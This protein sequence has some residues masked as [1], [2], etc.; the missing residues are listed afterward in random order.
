MIKQL[1][2]EIDACIQNNCFYTALMAALTIPDACGKIEYPN[3]KPSNRYKFWCRDWLGYDK[4]SADENNTQISEDEIYEL[5]C[6]L[7]HEVK[8]PSKFN[9][10]PNTKF[11]L[12]VDNPMIGSIGTII[13]N[14]D[15][16]VKR[17][18]ISI[19]IKNIC[20]LVCHSAYIFINKN[21][22]KFEVEDEKLEI[23]D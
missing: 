15:G 5:R 17:K 11:K 8:F 4:R 23:F 14:F 6:S 3:E 19:N 18:E 12:Y 1:L 22:E 10:Q 7:F 9:T 20:Y 2:K 13:R 21:K 16:T